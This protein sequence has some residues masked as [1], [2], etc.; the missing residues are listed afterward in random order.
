MQRFST[1][2]RAQSQCSRHDSRHFGARAITLAGTV[3]VCFAFAFD[4]TA[5]HA[6][7]QG[8]P[9]PTKVESWI[10]PLNQKKLKI[11]W[12]GT[13]EYKAKKLPD[14]STE[15]PKAPWPFLLYI[16][17]VDSKESQKIGAIVF[18]DTRVALAS[19]PVKFVQ[20]TPE[21][22]IELPY[23]QSVK[24]IKDPT[25]VVLDTDF[26]VVGVVNEWKDFD[27]KGLLPLLQRAADAVYPVKLA[28]Y[29]GSVVEQ[30][31]LGE[32]TWK[33]EER[34][35]VLQTKAGTADPAKQKALDEECDKLEAEIADTDA[36]IEARCLEL[37][38]SLVVKA[39]EA[40]AL[41]TTF[42]S[43]K[44]KRKLTPQEL[45]AIESFREFS[46]NDNPIVRAAAVEDL[47]ALDSG[48]MVEFILA[49]CTDI[50]DRVIEAAGRALGKMTSDESMAALLAGLDH[51]N[52]KARAAC[53]LGFSR[54]TR[55]YPPAV[56][57]LVSIVRTGDDDNRR[58]AIV[59]LA[60]MKD[61]STIDALIEAL[62]DKIPALRVIAAEAL[63]ELKAT[64]AGAAL[65]A[66]VET[67]A[68]WALQKVAV[69][70]LGK[71]RVKESV[72]PLLKLFETREGVLLEAIHKTLVN[73]TGED[74]S[75]EAAFWRRWWDR[76]GAA[77]V[78]PTDEEL[79]AKRE[80]I[81]AANV[82]YKRPDAKTYHSIETLSKKLIFVIDVSA[83][84]GD[85]LTIPDTATKEQID[86]FGSRVK[87]DIAKNELIA[88]LGTL[89]S[90]VDFNI[91]TFSGNAKPWQSGLVSA[92]MRTSAIKFVSKLK[93][94]APSTGG[95]SNAPTTGGTGDEQKT[96]T[97]AAILAAFGFAD[98]G[99]TDW[100]TRGKVDTIFFVTDGLPTTGQIVDVPKMIDAV[101]EMN[102]TRGLTIHL[103][104]FDSEAAKRM[105]GLATRNGGKCVVR[106]FSSGG[107]P[108]PEGK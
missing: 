77:F 74:F 31:E 39:P 91:I 67:A 2:P 83:S 10:S 38:A 16:K 60:N 14:G 13:P 105:Q 107:A 22:A 9:A 61:P 37:K 97:F 106:D 27:D 24:G 57:K 70:A 81:A 32:K 65:L 35:A 69:D 23:L 15:P 36:A 7:A 102:R 79:A 64:K 6:A 1:L 40:E 108:E 88:M 80:K 51:S 34:V 82:G 54:I 25:L 43:S 48:L 68:D 17:G 12:E 41:P 76:A 99:A 28:T 73:I 95:R 47:G 45:E 66:Q 19:A 84:M 92:G 62:A 78:V 30:L 21:R 100:K 59:A 103:I 71:L 8:M 86:A 89:G 11:D 96:N 20:V 75:Y 104:I 55:A 49:A 58:A 53:A 90:N 56:P 5:R 33:S 29:V 85:K 93:P 46:H 94:L 63:G 52:S 4:F 44:T 18:G 42:G 26:K 72:E 3:F 101:C 87:M 98:E 50:D